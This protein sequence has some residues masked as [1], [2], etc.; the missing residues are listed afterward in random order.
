M[1]ESVSI[2]KQTYSPSKNFSYRLPYQQ[3]HMMWDIFNTLDDSHS[4]YIAKEDLGTAL[5][6]AGLIVSNGEI[7]DLIYENG[8]E[9]AKEISMDLYFI[10]VARYHR[11]QTIV[12]GKLVDGTYLQLPKL[13]K[14]MVLRV[15]DY[16]GDSKDPS[17]LRFNCVVI[18]EEGIGQRFKSEE[19]APAKVDIPWAQAKFSYSIQNWIRH[20]HD[21]NMHQLIAKFEYQ[22]EELGNKTLK[23]AFLG[24]YTDITASSSEKKKIYEKN[25]FGKKRVDLFT[26]K[27]IVTRHQQFVAPDEI[28]RKKLCNV[29]SSEALS[30]AEYDKF[31]SALPTGEEVYVRDNTGAPSFSKDMEGVYDAVMQNFR[32]FMLAED[33]DL[34]DI[35]DSMKEKERDSEG[36]AGQP[37]SPD[38][39]IG[40]GG[41]SE[42]SLSNQIIK[43][44]AG[45]E[46]GVMTGLQAGLDGMGVGINIFNDKSGSGTGSDLSVFKDGADVASITDGASDDEVSSS[47]GEEVYDF[48]D[49][50]D[51]SDILDDLIDGPK[52]NKNGGVYKNLLHDRSK[53]ISKLVVKT[54]DGFS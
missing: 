21:K 42:L 25:S 43:M 5:R 40:M 17:S 30:D 38:D 13:G 37:G 29:R 9:E 36:D 49:G 18:V 48:G 16:E 1:D 44:E 19:T 14:V 39:G 51:T 53:D 31:C 15:E 26:G 34:D 46:K 10:F 11:D 22:E 27:P 28:I 50:S 4:G 47:D 41:R 32:S 2:L 8:L 20:H 33:G 54:D 3:L 12:D 52:K 45:L 23:G 6:A 35:H 24:M 7:E